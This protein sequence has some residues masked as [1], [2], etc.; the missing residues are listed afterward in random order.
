PVHLYVGY[1]ALMA[2]GLFWLSRQA[3]PPANPGAIDLDSSQINLSPKTQ[4]QH[5]EA[6][7]AKVS[8]A[9]PETVRF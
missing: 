9:P 5:S 3:T 7:G 8:I 4:S 1:A 6:S 2:G